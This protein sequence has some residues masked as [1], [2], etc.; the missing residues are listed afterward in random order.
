[1]KKIFLI[2]VLGLMAFS[3]GCVGQGPEGIVFKDK[4]VPGCVPDLA[5]TDASWNG[6]NLVVKG[7]ATNNCTQNANDFSVKGQYY[8]KD[9]KDLG[10]ERVIVKD[11]DVK[12]KKS[13]TI[14]FP[15]PDRK[16]VKYELSIDRIYW[17][18]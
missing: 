5:I 7:E 8:A 6:T 15:D 12:N 2:I 4:E 18:Q 13:F 16:V 9:G 14:T 17:K 1:M 11:I 3:F 10:I